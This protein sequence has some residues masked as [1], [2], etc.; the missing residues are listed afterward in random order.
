[1][2][3]AKYSLLT[4]LLMMIVLTSCELEKSIDKTPFST[5]SADFSSF[6]V[7]GDSYPAGYQSAA[8][9]EQHQIYSFPNL[10]AQQ[11]GV[12]TF[13]QPLLGYPGIGV[14][15]SAG[16]GILELETLS[17]LSIVAQDYEDYPNFDKNNPYISSEVRD[18][19]KPYNNLSIPGIFLTDILNAAIY[20]FSESK[21]PL[22]NTILRC[23]FAHQKTVVDQLKEL[24]PTFVLCMAGNS[25]MLDYALSGGTSDN[26]M[27]T[28]VEFGDLYA[29][30]MDSLKATGADIVTGN[31]P[32]IQTLPFFNTLEPYVI[33]TLTGLPALVDDEKVPFIGV[34]PE[35]DLV[36]LTAMASI[37][38]GLGV[39]IEYG[40]TDEPLPDEDFLNAEEISELGEKITAYNAA[41]SSICGS[42]DIPVFNFNVFLNDLQETGYEIVGY[43]FE[44]EFLTGGFFSLDGIHPNDAG[45]ALLAN[46]WIDL[47]NNSFNANI[48]SVDVKKILDGK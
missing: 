34:D 38:E 44:G 29:E 10:I 17:P 6:A 28:A 46:R 27:P 22:I 35:T 13:Q 33:D 15:T 7:I 43:T 26:P 4:L 8:L 3:I 12:D 39:P 30:L 40:G 24:N 42:R 48:P 23:D 11:A 9:T 25:D 19:P 47:I 1:M 36:L 20:E 32:D 41:I 21:S 31:I 45:N 37:S 16:Y 2:K 18:Y 5:G 14:Y